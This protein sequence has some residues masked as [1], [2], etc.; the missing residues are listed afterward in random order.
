MHSN[1]SRRSNKISICCYSVYG[2][3]LL[4]V[5]AHTGIIQM[6]SQQ[7]SKPYVSQLLR[8]AHGR[9]LELQ[10]LHQRVQNFVIIAPELLPNEFSRKAFA[11]LGDHQRTELEKALEFDWQKLST[12][13]NL[14]DLKHINTP[15]LRYLNTIHAELLKALPVY[16]VL[17][18]QAERKL[19]APSLEML[20]IS[21]KIC[22]NENYD[23]EIHFSVFGCSHLLIIPQ[24]KSGL[25][26]MLIVL[27]PSRVQTGWFIV[28]FVQGEINVILRSTDGTHFQKIIHVETDQKRTFGY[29]YTSW[30]KKNF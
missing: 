2:A 7:S 30:L 22:G 23:A 25:E 8:A 17:L 14:S 18:E 19:S 15:A 1:P 20:N 21:N 11:L 24:R 3:P 5:T 10:E 12:I 27:D 16:S 9:V 6:D 29:K 4:Y 26:P 13:L 28:P